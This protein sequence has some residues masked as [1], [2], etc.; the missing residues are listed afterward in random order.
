LVRGLEF[1]SECG[2]SEGEKGSE[3]HEGYLRKR[4]SNRKGHR[5]IARSAGEDKSFGLGGGGGAD[6]GT[7]AKGF[8][9]KTKKAREETARPMNG[10]GKVTPKRTG[11]KRWKPGREGGTSWLLTRV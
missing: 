10:R 5:V 4:V 1:T 9:M 6:G 7:G 8:G 2:W 11:Y 3:V